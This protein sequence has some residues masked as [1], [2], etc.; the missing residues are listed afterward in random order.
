M[1]QERELICAAVLAR[2]SSRYHAVAYILYEQNPMV[3]LLPLASHTSKP[4]VFIVFEPSAI[5]LI[6]E[7]HTGTRVVDV[8]SY[9]DPQL[10]EKLT[11]SLQAF[12]VS[13]WTDND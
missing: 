10:L 6:V 7:R 5:K 11:L 3:R 12:N 13:L 1:N 9:E 8:F 4:T 2:I